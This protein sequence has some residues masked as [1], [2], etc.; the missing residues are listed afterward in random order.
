[1]ATLPDLSKRGRQTMPTLSSL[2]KC[3]S[4]SGGRVAPPGHASLGRLAAEYINDEDGL[5]PA[6]FLLLTPL[7]RSA[8]Y[9]R[10][11][12]RVS[13]LKPVDAWSLDGLHY[14]VFALTRPEE[15]A[16]DPYALFVMNG[17]ARPVSAL[18]IQPSEND[19]EADVEDLC[20]PGAPPSRMQI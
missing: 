18:V 19:A 17:E 15:S 16:A 5:A 8:E 11:R 14:F 4:C 13:T 6:D 10:I 7:K 20:L 12:S 1:M 3:K 2:R 9:G